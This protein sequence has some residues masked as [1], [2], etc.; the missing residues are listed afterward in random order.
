MSLDCVEQSSEDLFH[1]S[2]GNL[3]VKGA[4]LR[5]RE[6]RVFRGDK[7]G[8]SQVNVGAFASQC[9]APLETDS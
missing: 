4:E 8:V 1:T 6:E 3:S 7:E 5:P 9:R 2:F